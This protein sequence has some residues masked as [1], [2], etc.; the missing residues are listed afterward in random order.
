MNIQSRRIRGGKDRLG[1]SGFFLWAPHHDE[2]AVRLD[3]GLILDHA[4]F[5]RPDTVERGAERGQAGDKYGVLDAGNDDR[6]EKAQHHYRPGR[7]RGKEEP[8]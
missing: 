2:K 5:R 1:A 6:G 7:R 8:G 4:V 3:V